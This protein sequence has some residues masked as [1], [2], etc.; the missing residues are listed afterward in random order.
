MPASFVQRKARPLIFLS[1][2]ILLGA[3]LSRLAASGS[4]P[5]SPTLPPPGPHDA[6]GAARAGQLAGPAPGGP[7]PNAPGQRQYAQIAGPPGPGAQ[8]QVPWATYRVFA[9]RYDPNTVGSVEVAVPD[10]CVKFAALGDTNDLANFHCGPGYPVGLD[11]RVLITRD[12]GQSMYIP[13]KDVG[14]WNIDDNYWD[15]ADPSYPRPR[16]MFG[17]LARGTPE[18][19]AAYYSGYNTVSNCNNLDGSPSGHP[20]GADQ[21]GRCVLNPSAVDISTA[22]AAQIG[23][24]GAEWVTAS[25]VWEP[26]DGLLAFPYGFRGGAFVASGDFDLDGK[27]EVVAGADAGGGPDVEV[28]QPNGVHVG[29]FYAFPA[30]FRGGVRVASGSL[31][32]GNNVVTAAGAGGGPAVELFHANGQNIGGFYAYAPNFTGGVYVA[33]GHVTSATGDQIVTGAGAGGGPHVRVF[34]ADGTPVGGFMAYD[35]SFPGG[36]RVATGDV[37]GNGT[38]DIVTGAGPGGGPHVRIFRADGTPV[39]GFMAYDPSFHGGVYVGTVRAPDNKSDWIVT[40]AGEGGG[41]HIKI[42]DAA[43]NLEASFMLT[44]DG[45]SSGV[46]PASGHWTTAPGDLFVTQG[47]GALPLVRFRHTDGTIFWP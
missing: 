2:L 46:R 41:P 20:G 28:Y 35:T 3:A 37:E 21:F 12:N 33:A 36:V 15:P 16:R 31:A 45:D 19:Q 1:A 22:A 24:S 9:T 7:A 25:F 23:F 44:G 34:A 18:S 10:K 4:S 29:G 11:Y 32:G 13:V 14:P 42:W 8:P 40:G 38:A 27:S 39:G 30:G 47:P 6:V 17:D 26:V 5:A 43:G